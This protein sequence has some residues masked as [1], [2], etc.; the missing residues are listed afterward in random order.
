VVAGLNGNFRKYDPAKDDRLAVVGQVLGIDKNLPTAGFLQ[1]Y[2]DLINPEVAAIIKSISLPPSPG[3]PASDKDAAYPYGVP[4]TNQG[5]KSD[6]EKLLG[7]KNPLLQHNG[8][9]FLTDGFF[10]A[11]ELRTNVAINDAV[12]IEVVRHSDGGT[13]VTGDTVTVPADVYNGAIFIKVKYKLDQTRLD[14][15]Q[16]KHAGG[17]FSKNDIHLDLANNTIVAYLAP[18][19]TYTAVKVDLPVVVDPIAGTP[20][21]WDYKGSVGGIRILLQK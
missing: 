14:D 3:K 16:V 7:I 20:T 19:T 1:Y 21:E 5:W 10:R 6:F 12:N 13:T 4:Y 2:A 15:I 18:G 11:Q 17:T 8:I 9:P